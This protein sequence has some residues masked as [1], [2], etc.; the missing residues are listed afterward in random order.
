MINEIIKDNKK[1][2]E[3]PPKIEEVKT[4]N[5]NKKEEDSFSQLLSLQ[6]L[7]QKHSGLKELCKKYYFFI[8]LI[9]YLDIKERDD[10]IAKIK[11]L[12]AKIWELKLVIDKRTSNKK[13]NSYQFNP[14][15]DKLSINKIYIS[16]LL[17]TLWCCPEIMHHVLENTNPEVIKSNL[18]PL[19]V[20]NCYF[21][22][23]SGNYLESN[24]LYVITMLLKEEIDK[25]ENINQVDKFLEETKCGYLLE[26]FRKMP[27]IQIY[28]KNVI[29][30]TIQ[31]IEKDYSFREIKFNV[32]EYLKEINQ[33][34]NEE[35]KKISKKKKNIED[36]DNK[37]LDE[38]YKKIINSQVRDSSI[39]YDEG[40]AQIYDERNEKF[41]KNYMPDLTG[42]VFETREEKAKNENKD[43]LFKYFQKLENNIKSND[44]NYLYANKILLQKMSDS[45]CY[46]YLISFYQND[47]LQVISFLEQLINDFK[48]NILLI[49]NSIKSICKI[50]SILLK[51]KF[52]DITQLEMN[53]FLSRFVIEKILI[54]TISVPNF[55]AFIS[56]FVIS[57]ITVKN[58][59]II[60]IILKKLFSGKLFLNDET[61]SGYTPFNWF[62]IDKMEDIFYCFEKMTN[63]NLPTFIEQYINDEL[64]QDYYYDYF[65]ENK[66]DFI[67]NISMCFTKENIYHLI[68]GIK[69][70]DKV[71]QRND[72][73]IFKLKKVFKKLKPSDYKDIS[74]QNDSKSFSTFAEKN[75]KKDSKRPSSSF[76][77]TFTVK[78]PGKKESNKDTENVIN[79]E[80]NAEDYFLYCD[81]IIEKSCENLFKI[82]NKI[83]NFYI[84]IKKVEKNK[85]LNE[86]ET[87][88]DKEK[89]NIIKVKNYLCNSLGNYRLLNRTD[90]KVET[91]SSTKKMLNEIKTY[92]H[93]PNFILNNNTIPSVWYITSLLDYLDDIP[94]DYKE[95]DFKKLFNELTRNLNESINSLD[96][97]KLIVFRNKLKFIEKINNYYEEARKLINNI[98]INDNIKHIVEEAFIPVDIIFDYSEKEKKFDLIKSNLKDKAFDNKLICEGSKKKW[99]SFRTIEAFTRYFPNIAKYQ[100][101]Q[102]ISPLSIIREL[103]IN[104]KINEYFQIIKE[105]IIKKLMDEKKYTG[106][107]EEKIKN[108]IMNKIYDKIY[109]SEPSSNDVEVFKKSFALSWVEAH[110]LIDKEYIFDNMLPDILNEFKQINILKT[111]YKK[112]NCFIKILASVINLIKFNEGEDKEVGADDITPILSFVA[113]KAHPF[114][115][116]TDIEFIRLFSENNGDNI[117]SLVNIENIYKSILLSFSEKNLNISKEEYDKNCLAAMKENENKEEFIYNFDN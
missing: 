4:L 45:K 58:I 104:K 86:S 107:Y 38:F 78:E 77:K 10:G 52:P 48:N 28:F 43:N 13:E 101:M 76:L 63:V 9:F 81:N 18:A 32:D 74:R 110:H 8:I 102:D 36:N 72:T 66:E 115:I 25:L 108:Y 94:E 2:T 31:K 11:E 27:D 5:D 95:D 67:A 84:K 16:Q 15:M 73:N 68:K 1:I 29:R 113:I 14:N 114:K 98:V 51:N 44:N 57:G 22:F 62:F 111:P 96:F 99:T 106:L 24:L 80:N 17:K 42:R 85:E 91:T 20:N 71:F 35:E 61:E 82:N 19:V 50:I 21:N 70:E 46:N 69:L 55:N 33:Y 3:E 60:N 39:N 56:D 64:P 92:M 83:A 109:P 90:Y 97:E 54:P 105:K 53:G 26:E 65:N 37:D 40:N 6:L 7:I 34:R 100:F 117:N 41:L 112:L 75:D 87:K 49:P 47:F 88:E 12:A 103:S 116:F 30:K 79:K 23:L 89:I 59:K 93:L